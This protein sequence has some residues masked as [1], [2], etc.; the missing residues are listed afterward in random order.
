MLVPI[1]TTLLKLIPT[2]IQKNNNSKGTSK[3]LLIEVNRNLK[4]ILNAIKMKIDFDAMID[5]LDNKEINKAIKNNY[6][7]NKIKHWTIK[8]KHIKD[9]RNKRLIGKDCK[10]LFNN[11]NM[12]IQELKDLKEMNKSVLNLQNTNITLKIT[13]LL[14]KYKL[15][16]YFIK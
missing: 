6:N 13:N 5:I 14:F 11:I 10:W 1:V 2:I 3:L 8:S 12:K 4:N 9:V 7:F 16:I 15:L